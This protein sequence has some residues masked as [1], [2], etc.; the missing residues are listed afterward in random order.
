[1]KAI[2][3]AAG[4]GKRLGP[5]AEN[6]PK[7]LLKFGGRSLLQRHLYNLM[8][9]SVSEIVIVYGYKKNLIDAYIRSFPPSIIRTTLWAA[10]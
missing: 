8:S 10:W 9:L 6:K 3:L 1:M 4:V 5:A 2:I 7:C